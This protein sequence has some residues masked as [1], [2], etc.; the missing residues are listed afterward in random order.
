MKYSLLTVIVILATIPFA[1]ADA[2]GPV[3]NV[4]LIVSDDL[5]AS[6]LACYGDRF[7]RSPNID[8]LANRGLVFERAYCQGTS[9]GPSRRSFM[10][11]RYAHGRSAVR[12][13]VNLGQ[14]FRQSG[15]YSARV[16]KIFHMRVPGDII[17]GSDG[18]DYRSAWTERFNSAGR[19]AH[20]PGDYAC[21]NLNVFTRSLE[22]RQSTRMPHRM[23]VSVQH[24]GDGSDQPDHKSADQAIELLRQ[25]RDEPFFLAVGMVRPHY[26]MVAPRQYFKSYRWQ[27]MKLP[28]QVEGDVDDIPRPGRAR[29]MSS[30]NPIGKYPDNQRR[31]WAAYYAAITFMDEQVGRV[32][33]ELD[34]L[35]LA[36]ETAIVFTSD[37]GY[38]LGDHGFWQKSNLHE[39]VIRVPLIVAGPGVESGR[40]SSIVELTDLYP[41]LA[42]LCGFN[43]PETVQG[44]SFA[45]VLS[46]PDAETRDSALTVDRGASLRTPGWHYIRYNPNAA[47]L[48]D[49]R[50][51]PWQL[52]NLIG[53]VSYQVVVDRL[54]QRLGER[55]QAAGLGEE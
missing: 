27:E 30:N 41:T 22:N 39:E 55:L 42:A 1:Q 15:W 6:A 47:E 48:Y 40:T 52:R 54:D 26:P 12:G 3:K 35:G 28:P 32:I 31:M 20:T 21:L 53:D 49:M 7:C 5:R 10:F 16:G 34:R 23:F 44:R 43:V 29:T 51:D 18:E 14:L 13:K 46:D 24:D 11:S 2:V 38:H 9:C 33:D 25:H 4:L 8:A 37:H 19:E 36:D 50:A 17:A 45:P